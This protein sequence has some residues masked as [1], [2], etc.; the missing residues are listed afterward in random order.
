M[1]FLTAELGPVAS[2]GGAAA[3]EAT[4]GYVLAIWDVIKDLWKDHEAEIKRCCAP[5][6]PKE[7]IDRVHDRAGCGSLWP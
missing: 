5:S 1:M 6:M 7:L 2:G 3:T 4:V